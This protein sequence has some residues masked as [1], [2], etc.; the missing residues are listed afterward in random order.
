[1]IEFQGAKAVDEATGRVLL[2]SLSLNLTEQ[3][4]A[5]IGANGS[6]KSTLLKVVN[7]LVPL[8]TGDVVVNGI[9]VQGNSSQVRSRV[10]FVFTDPAAQLVMPTPLE[11]VQLSLRKARTTRQERLAK[12]IRHLELFGLS[13]QAHQSI[14]SLSGGERQLAALASVLAVEPEVL[15]MD[16]PTTLLDLSNTLRL[17]GLLAQLPQ[18]L[19]IAT[20][21]LDWALTMDRV[22][23][24]QD[25]RVAFDGD[26]GKAVERYR[27]AARLG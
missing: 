26:P 25:A 2:D 10:G 17:R 23:W 15:L 13:E 12:A 22:L 27:A 6:G 21:D 20:H 14:F 1:M 9:S 7:G 3:R 11:D 5:L 4:V 8:A 18:Q 16:E 24:I 19:I